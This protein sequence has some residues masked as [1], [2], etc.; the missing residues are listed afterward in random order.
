MKKMIVLLFVLLLAGCGAEQITGTF[1]LDAAQGF[2]SED[3]YE[4]P[5]K[6]IIERNYDKVFV[7]KNVQGF[8]EEE[9][10]AMAEMTP[11]EF[12]EFIDNQSVAEDSIYDITLIEATTEE[13][14]LEYE[15]ERVVFTALSESYFKADD[16]TQYII[17]YDSPSIAEYEASLMGP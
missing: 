16:G 6:Y 8:T 9:L 3:N 14:V 2:I 12:K 4:T 10:A 7:D 5:K 15:G 1:T 13:I 17:E 11:E